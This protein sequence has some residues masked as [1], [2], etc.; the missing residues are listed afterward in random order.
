MNSERKLPS[1]AP[2][3]GLGWAALLLSGSI[4]VA[5]PVGGP[6][7]VPE[8]KNRIEPAL[9][10]RVSVSQPEVIGR[11]VGTLDLVSID[12]STVTRIDIYDLTRNGFGEG[13]VAHIHPS[14]EVRI[15]AAIEP[16]LREE[17]SAWRSAEQSE[18]HFS[19]S[20]DPDSLETLRSPRAAI[21]AGVMRAVG[22]N[23]GSGLPFGLMMTSDGQE[24][25]VFEMWG[26]ESDSLR[27]RPPAENAGKMHYDLVDVVRRQTEIV[28]DSVAYDL[29]YIRT[30][31]IDTLYL[32]LPATRPTAGETEIPREAAHESP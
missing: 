31:S 20:M 21:A 29:L 30:H 15:I 13:D 3:W 12:P 17:M 7:T 9:V 28:A 1:V 25:A 11:L 4:V 32:P 27:Y 16:E 18:Q 6:R 14:E 19:A 22:R 5:Q 10:S 24:R 8:G 26:F 23:Y 2:L